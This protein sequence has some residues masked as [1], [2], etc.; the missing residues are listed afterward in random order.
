MIPNSF[1]QF[2]DHPCTIDKPFVIL[3]LLH[4]PTALFDHEPAAWSEA[5]EPHLGTGTFYSHICNKRIYLAKLANSFLP[6]RHFLNNLWLKSKVCCQFSNAV[7]QQKKSFSY[8][9]GL[10]SEVN[11]SLILEKRPPN[12][13]DHILKYYFS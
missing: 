1:F 13:A 6:V 9:K 3:C 8:F 11:E 7:C 12:L 4:R 5:Q 10:V 2:L